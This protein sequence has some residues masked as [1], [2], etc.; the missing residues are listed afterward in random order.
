MNDFIE[1][2]G[3]PCAPCTGKVP[4]MA[5][6]SIA[7]LLKQLDRDWQIVENHHLVKTFGF[8]DWNGAMAF[9][10]AV[11]DI[12]EA[13]N[14]HP[15]LLVQWG[16]VTVTIYTHKIDGLVLSDFIFAAKVQESAERD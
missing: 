1:L 14:H 5:P 10:N 9:A 3:R 11:S 16:K 12:A 7:A 6:N 8:D 15:D 2:A 4:P 13:Q